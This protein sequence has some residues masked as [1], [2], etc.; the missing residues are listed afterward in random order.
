MITHKK[1]MV[2]YET[3][4]IDYVTCD[5]CNKDIT[6]EKFFKLD[7][8]FYQL[9][10]SNQRFI[11]KV[12]DENNGVAHICIECANSIER[13]KEKITKSKIIFPPKGG[14]GESKSK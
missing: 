10:D 2:S 8:G 3:E 13:V 9:C 5:F 4:V 1:E 7:I 11:E 12:Y 6:N 14:T